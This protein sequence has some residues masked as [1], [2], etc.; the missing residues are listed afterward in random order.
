M[1]D[2]SNSHNTATMHSATTTQTMH[3]HHASSRRPHHLAPNGSPSNSFHTKTPSHHTKPVLPPWLHMPEAIV[4]LEPGG[5][6][7]LIVSP[8][9][10]A[11]NPSLIGTSM[12]DII[13]E[14]ERH[15]L[16]DAM[17]EATRTKLPADRTA[18]SSC[19]AP[20]GEVSQWIAYKVHPIVQ[21]IG[22][23]NV[24]VDHEAVVTKY[25]V[26]RIDITESRV[27]DA[28]KL[29]GSNL[30]QSL[31]K[32]TSLNEVL[33]QMIKTIEDMRPGIACVVWI[34]DPTTHN[35][36][37]GAAPSFSNNFIEALPT[38][39]FPAGH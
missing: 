32:T 11:F 8:N 35:L 18:I 27:M 33:W 17:D 3:P 13:N 39:G 4:M 7:A 24:K 12:Y 19:D 34:L 25:M 37:L 1:R 30:S 6:I 28:I 29:A 26:T 9:T 31:S 15:A 20:A 5:R 14:S 2:N 36:Q 16:R 21:H 38:E 10:S 23:G 22:H